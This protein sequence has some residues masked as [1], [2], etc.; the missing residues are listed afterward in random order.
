[1]LHSLIANQ[2]DAL[3]LRE[4]DTVLPIVPMF[5]ANAWGLPYAAALAGSKLVLPG[6]RMDPAQ[7]ASLIAEEHVTFAGAVPTIWQ[8]MAQLDPAPDLCSIES[9]AAARPCPRV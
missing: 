3:G 7:L 4:R 1:V 5:H 9:C 2:A 6:P 8:G